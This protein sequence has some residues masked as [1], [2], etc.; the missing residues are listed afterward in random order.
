MAFPWKPCRQT[1]NRTAHFSSYKQ[2]KGNDHRT[3]AT[4]NL[5]AIKTC[6]PATVYISQH[7]IQKYWIINVQKENVI[8]RVIK[9]YERED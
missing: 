6:L 7:N 5:H 8:A 2:T 9:N 1:D 3:E 4:V